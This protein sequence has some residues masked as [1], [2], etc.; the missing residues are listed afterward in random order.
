M[1]AG[2]PRRAMTLAM[3]KVFARAGHAQQGLKGFAVFHALHQ[4][5]NGGG[6]SRRQGDK[7]GTGERA[8]REIPQTHLQQGQ[9]RHG[10]MLSAALWPCVCGALCC[11]EEAWVSPH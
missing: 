9:R 6:L 1:M 8:S 5:F 11:S 7:V 3:V 2:R 4:L 10:Q